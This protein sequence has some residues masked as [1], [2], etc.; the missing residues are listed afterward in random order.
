M[1]TQSNNL[2]QQA[3]ELLQQGKA[4]MAKPLLEDALI[5]DLENKEILF[6]IRCANYWGSAL[7]SVEGIV[8]PFEKGEKI[9]D[10]WKKFVTDI[11]GGESSLYEKSMYSVRKGVFSIALELYK[12]TLTDHYQL[13][14]AESYRKVAFCYKQLGFYEQALSFLAEANAILENLT[15]RE[16]IASILAEMADCY[17]LCGQDNYAK[18]LFREAFFLVPG[19]IELV[20]LDSEL[21]VSLLKL[22]SEKGYPE[23]VMREW[24]PVYGVLYGVF[25]VKRQL[26]PVEFSTLRRDIVNL[27]NEIQVSQ[28]DKRALLV[29]RLINKYFWQIDHYVATNDD[30]EKIQ[31]TLRK[32]K[33]LDEEVYRKYTM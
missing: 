6:A 18:V 15:K 24:I 27:E 11:V 3:Y 30:R 7:F 19:N 21:I 20:F 28:D 26:R 1:S 9:I 14:R 4:D 16:D 10:C 2:L 8:S 25:N 12:Q 17:S 33:L 29:P 31:E 5:G 32:I 23:V 13:Q 22:V